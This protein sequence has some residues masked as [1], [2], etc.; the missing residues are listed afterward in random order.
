MTP[1][2]LFWSTLGAI[3][4]AT[5]KLRPAVNRST[6]LSGMATCASATPAPWKFSAAPP[7]FPATHVVSPRTTPLSL[8][9]DASAIATPLPS[10]NCQYPT[11]PG[12]VTVAADATFDGAD[13]AAFCVDRTR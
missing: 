13:D 9:P 7:T 3:H 11:R 4:A 2:H 8:F 6:G 1:A 5:V 10:S 12:T